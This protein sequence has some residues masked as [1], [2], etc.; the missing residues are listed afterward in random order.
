MKPVKTKNTNCTLKGNNDDV[1]DLPVT[2]FEYD[3]GTPAVESC[4][5]LSQE[6]LKEIKKTGRLYF[7]CFGNTHPP[8]LLSSDSIF[9]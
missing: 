5:E 8:I 7:R 9:K 4:W 1:I 2:R 3:D 6:E